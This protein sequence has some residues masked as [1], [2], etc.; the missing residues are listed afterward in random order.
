MSARGQ[1][2]GGYLILEYYIYIWRKIA[3][4][5]QNPNVVKNGRLMALLCSYVII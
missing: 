4:V 1:N 5:E 3:H 2:N